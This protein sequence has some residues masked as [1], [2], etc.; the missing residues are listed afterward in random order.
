MTKTTATCSGD[1]LP[2]ADLVEKDGRARTGWRRRRRRTRRRSEGPGARSGPSSGRSTPVAVPPVVVHRGDDE[3]DRR[4]PVRANAEK[5]RVD[6]EVDDV[7]RDPDHA[8]LR[9]LYPVV[10]AAGALMDRRGS[11]AWPNQDRGYSVD[12]AVRSRA[13][14][15]EPG[16]SLTSR[17]APPSRSKTQS[18]WL[19]RPPSGRAS[20]PPS[21]S[22]AGS[23]AG[24]LLR[25]RGDRNS[26]ERR[27]FG[28]PERAVALVHLDVPGPRELE[29]R[30]RRLGELRDHL[31]RAHLSCEPRR[32][33]RPDSPSRCR[34]RADAL[35]AGKRKPTADVGD[36]ER[37]G[38]G[39]AVWERKRRVVVCMRSRRPDG[40]NNSR[41]TRL[42][43]SSTAFVVDAATSQLGVNPGRGL[44]A[45]LATPT[46][47]KCSAGELSSD[48]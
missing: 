29:R 48:R 28:Q 18:C 15:T 6:R 12:R 38:D 23:A 16:A 37:L 46:P 19:R 2:P 26:R 1:D 7:A 40:T 35:A 45:A 33:R 42:M 25:R 31:D 11:R 30:P 47:K 43:A 32:G 27:Q 8:E 13:V 21:S 4:R 17:S 22:C 20:R 5:H 14:R 36:D 44:H 10:R 41:G 39:L 3:R 9:E 34:R 24:T